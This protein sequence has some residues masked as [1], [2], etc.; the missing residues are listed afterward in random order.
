MHKPGTLTIAK[1]EPPI[2][3]WCKPKGAKL[4]TMLV[5]SETNTEQAN[6]AYDLPSISQTV[7]YHHTSAGFPVADTWIKAIKAGNYNTW[8]T[9]TPATV[10]RHFPESNETQKGHMKKQRQGIR[11]TSVLAETTD[12]TCI[13]ALPKM[14]DI[15]IKI[16]NAT[17]TIHSNQ[18]GCFPAI[19]SRGNKY[20]MVLVKVDG[21]Y[22]DA[23]SMKNKSEGSMIKTYLALR[24]RLTP[25]GTVK[26]KTHIMDNEASEEYKEEKKKIAR[27]NSP[28][29]QPQTKSCKTSNTNLQKTLQGNPCGSTQ[30]VFSATM[31]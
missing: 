21:N 22:I 30:H 31:G 14:K 12:V 19:L 5:Q 16:Y 23:E 15:Y 6:N 25:P 24:N 11:S 4:W 13:P 7:R 3:Q 17:K 26:P 1:T 18:T 29:G 27:S 2:L 20:I 10:Q 8:P 28:T 9:I